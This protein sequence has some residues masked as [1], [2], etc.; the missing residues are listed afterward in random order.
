MKRLVILLGFIF[1][2]NLYGCKMSAVIK[3]GYIGPLTGKYSDLGLSGR[4]GAMLAVEKINETGG[5]AGR[6]IELL[7]YDENLILLM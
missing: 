1:L 7:V 4:N 2:C 3:I 6:N 5:L